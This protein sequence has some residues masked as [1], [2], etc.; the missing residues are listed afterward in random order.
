MKQY[1][2]TN[3]SSIG[4]PNMKKILQYIRDNYSKPLTLR[5]VAAHFHFNPSYLS[6]Y[7]TTHNKE[8]FVEYLNKVRTEEA[9]KLLEGNSYSISEIGSMVGYSES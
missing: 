9:S 6:N 5:E 7:F 3:E 1:I 8:G 2:S 4:N